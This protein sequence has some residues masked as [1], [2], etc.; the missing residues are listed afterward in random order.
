M[1]TI[2]KL[3]LLF[4]L[5][6]V[7]SHLVARALFNKDPV[8]FF[9]AEEYQDQFAASCAVVDSSDTDFEKG[10]SG[11]LLSNGKILTAKHVPDNNGNG[12]IEENEKDVLLK[13]YYPKEFTCR[14]RVIYAPP[15]KNIIGRGFDFCIIKPEL[16]IGSNIRLAT[17][18][19]H[20]YFGAGEKIYTI[21]R[22]DVHQ[23]TIDFGNHTTRLKGG[24]L[25]D[26]AH[27]DI[28][29]G[30]SGGGVFRTDDGVLAGIISLK[31]KVKTGWAGSTVWAGYIGAYDIRR[32]LMYADMEYLIQDYY[33]MYDYKLRKFMRCSIIIL[34][35]FLGVYFGRSVLCEEVWD[36]QR[37]DAIV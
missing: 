19:E 16:P 22:K 34:N 36:L 33:D 15:E 6:F 26:R 31:R 21:G 35:C 23:P 8:T 14:G 11:V 9:V 12:I 29:Y 28:W 27:L 1:N 5:T 25:Y 4:C 37:D 32:Y 13:F 10:A 7:A 30:N 3:I 18:E 2:L 17:L 20:Y 24:F